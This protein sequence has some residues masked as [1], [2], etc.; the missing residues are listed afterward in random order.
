MLP[1]AADMLQLLSNTKEG[2]IAGIS[3]QQDSPNDYRHST[4]IMKRN[5]N[6]TSS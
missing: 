1:K 5:A 4:R 6:K 2:S 3:K